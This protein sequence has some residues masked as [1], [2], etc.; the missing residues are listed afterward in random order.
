M[1][2]E[3][4]L[5]Q[6]NV[7]LQSVESIV[8][9]LQEVRQYPNDEEQ[10]WWDCQHVQL[11]CQSISQEDYHEN[12]S[13]LETSSE[14]NNNIEDEEA[15][16]AV[17]DLGPLCSVHEVEKHAE[18]YHALLRAFVEADPEQGGVVTRQSFA[19]LLDTAA[20][21]LAAHGDCA[22][23][24]EDEDA[25]QA[26]FEAVN[27]SK[28]GLI[29]YN[30][31]YEFCREHLGVASTMSVSA[32]STPTAQ[33]TLYYGDEPDSTGDESEETPDQ[34][35]PGQNDIVMS[36]LLS[37]ISF[38]APN[39]IFNP[40]KSMRLKKKKWR[41]RTKKELHPH[42]LRMW[43]HSSELF[44]P[45]DAPPA[46][47]PAPPSPYPVVDW[48]QVN[49]RFLGNLPEPTPFPLS[50][51]SPDEKFYRD[52]DKQGSYTNTRWKLGDAFGSR[53]GYLTEDGVIAP[54]GSGQ[55]IHGYVWSDQFRCWVLQTKKKDVKKKVPINSKQ[56]LE[57][58]EKSR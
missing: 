17:S 58:K 38:C 46:T 1:F 30:E 41:K 43:Q 15:R 28:S 42:L 39:L 56:K 19:Q 50:G 29:S 25:M 2:R 3:R 54:S 32:S 8:S 33:Y 26:M 52:C 11:Q 44:S 47:V 55:M 12:C 4:I 22:Y 27:L 45:P 10:L 16:C 36:N 40:K 20:D 24:L 6:I 7:I 13:Y 49:K 14:I 48:S 37:C 34:Q 53:R 5:S 21:V 57:R 35:Q 18:V 23:I 51:C 9:Q 31:W